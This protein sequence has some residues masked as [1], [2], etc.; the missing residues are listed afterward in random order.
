MKG[1]I[2]CGWVFKKKRKERGRE[3]CAAGC[4]GEKGNG[5]CFQGAL[6][7]FGFER[8]GEKVGVNTGGLAWKGKSTYLKGSRRSHVHKTRHRLIADL[9]IALRTAKIKK[10]EEWVGGHRMLEGGNIRQVCNTRFPLWERFL[11]EGKDS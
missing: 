1:G 10:R 6:F 3:E 5:I 11:L 2:F 7:S 8:W 4:Y 9:F